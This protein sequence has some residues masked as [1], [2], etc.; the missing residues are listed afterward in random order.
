M[1]ENT[2]PETNPFDRIR[3]RIIKWAAVIVVFVVLPLA[4]WWAGR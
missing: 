1:N 3:D 4:L 2:D